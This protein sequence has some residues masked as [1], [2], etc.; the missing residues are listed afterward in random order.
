MS[1]LQIKFE[2]SPLTQFRGKLYPFSFVLLD[3]L[4]IQVIQLIS[5][6]QLR[7]VIYPQSADKSLFTHF[8]IIFY[9]FLN[10]RE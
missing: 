5:D 8:L 10:P 4:Y 7:V 1:F 3:K 9:I 6:K 2:E